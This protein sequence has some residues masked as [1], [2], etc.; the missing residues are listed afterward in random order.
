VPD[1]LNE[2]IL[3]AIAKDPAQR[4]Q[5]ATAMRGALN[6]VRKD[7]GYEVKTTPSPTVMP[8]PIVPLPPETGAGRSRRG[9]YM[10]LGSVVTVGVLIAALLLIPK[11]TKTGASA[12]PPAPAPAAETSAPP[13]SPPP[14]EPAPVPAPP[15]QTTSQEP[16][17]VPAPP[18]LN[19]PSRREPAKDAAP[20]HAAAPAARPPASQPRSPS[21]QQPVA[22]QAAQPQPTQPP[23]TPAQPAAPAA[24]LN[25]ARERYNNLAIRAGTAKTGLQSLQN[26]MGGLG[27]RA[28]M[29]E[30]AARMDYLM[31][32]AMTSLRASDLDGSRRNMDLAE[33]T[34]DRI[35]TFLGRR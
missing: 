11:Y 35:E 22:S 31:Q 18:V 21:T 30:A 9:L 17:P 14:A 13:A 27:L 6:S 15:A 19:N 10:A 32:E 8:A 16:A 26:Q 33:R 23:P 1:A 2:V 7:L 25:E 20:A 29:R 34:I 4:F 24:A 3:M 28:D 12:S 5:S